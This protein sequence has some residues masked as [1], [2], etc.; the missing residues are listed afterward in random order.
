M[1]NARFP[2]REAGVFICAAH[3]GDAVNRRDPASKTVGD[4]AD[5]L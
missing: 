5:M 4:S 1:E 3:R 2:K